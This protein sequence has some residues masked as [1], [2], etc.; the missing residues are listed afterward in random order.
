I[1][2]HTICWRFACIVFNFLMKYSAY[3]LNIFNQVRFLIHC[4]KG[5]FK[6]KSLLFL[7]IPVGCGKGVC[8]A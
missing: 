4:G 6:A 8:I 5:C 2:R 1:N 7:K 3:I